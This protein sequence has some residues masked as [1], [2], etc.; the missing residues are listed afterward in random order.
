[1]RHR[2]AYQGEGGEVH[3]RLDLVRLQDGLQAC[4]IVQIPLDQPSRQHRCAM[5]GHQI[6][7]NPD[8]VTGPVEP[9]RGMGTDIACATGNQDSHVEPSSLEDL[10]VKFRRLPWM[11]LNN[12]SNAEAIRPTWHDRV[13]GGSRKTPGPPTN[14]MGRQDR[15]IVQRSQVG[16]GTLLVPSPACGRGLG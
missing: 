4:P 13:D 8:F 14:G 6:V 15:E 7:V 12:N 2:L 1:M 3:D 9:P 10:P 11:P 5:A 16:N